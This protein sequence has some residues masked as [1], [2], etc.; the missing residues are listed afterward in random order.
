MREMKTADLIGP[1]L[2]WA[3]ADV[4]GAYRGMHEICENGDPWPAWI[5]PNGVPFKATTG[6]FKPSSDWSHGGPL[7]A[8]YRVSLEDIGIGWIAT[9]RCCTSAAGSMTPQASDSLLVAACR[10]IVCAGI[11]DTAQ[12]P[13][14]LA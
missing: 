7:I 12:I 2:D 5:F 10:A 6:E 9:P 14:D 13:D 4:I 8:E 11:G 1:A 3:V